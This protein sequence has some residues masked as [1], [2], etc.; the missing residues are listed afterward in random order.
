M[1]EV[2]LFRAARTALPGLCFRLYFPDHTV[3][4]QVKVRF[5]HHTVNLEP[6]MLIDGYIIGVMGFQ[7]NEHFVLLGII[8]DFIHQQFRKTM[9]LVG[10]IYSQINDM[11]PLCLVELVCPAG[12]QIILSENKIPEGLQA[13]VLFDQPTIRRNCG[14]EFREAL[15]QNV[16]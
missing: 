3:L 6:E 8:D 5:F 10:G 2:F 9:M 13:G 16:I 7:G 14:T 11:K 4:L 15:M 1:P 12:I